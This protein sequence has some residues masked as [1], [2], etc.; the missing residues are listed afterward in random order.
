MTQVMQVITIKKRLALLLQAQHRVELALGLVR[1]QRSQKL[2]PGTGHFHIDD[3]V[4]ARKAEQQLN[5]IR[6]E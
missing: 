6:V 1:D 2:H 3:E 5:L 4:S